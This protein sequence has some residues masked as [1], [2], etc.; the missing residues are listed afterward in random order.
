[1]DN[2][3]L[4]FAVVAGE[5]GTCEDGDCGGVSHGADFRYADPGC[6]A[7]RARFALDAAAAGNYEVWAWWPQGEDRST[8]TP[9]TVRH[10]DVA[11]TIRVDQRANGSAWYW[12][13]APTLRRGDSIEVI[14][15]GSSSGYANADALAI[16]PAGSQP[17]GPVAVR[18]PA[19]TPTPVPAVQP[20]GPAEDLRALTDYAKTIKPL[21]DQGLA[22]A[23]RDSALLEA[24]KDNPA[25]LCG[26]VRT[27]HPTLV[28]DA[29]LMADL[30]NQLKRA[31]PPD[32]AIDPVHRPL[33]ES[34]RLW[35]EALD[36]VNLSCK[37]SNQAT[38][39]VLRLGAALQLGG[40][41]VNFRLAS[42]NFWRLAIANGIEALAGTPPPS[43]R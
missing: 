34:L 21:L 7:C 6:T 22:A 24:S 18:P 11:Q 8:D 2:G 38:R 17:P 15:E 1:V 16:L 19:P 43:G 29:A 40:S 39:G 26:G 35:S 20:S 10:N 32:E 3:D 37:T 5:W 23:E 4:G 28:D 13:A 12:L 41:M 33:L 9:F 31:T 42:E 30:M 27:P 14:V 25:A 36:N